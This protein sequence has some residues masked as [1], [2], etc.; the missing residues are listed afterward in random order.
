ME[1]RVTLQFSRFIFTGRIS[2]VA[3]LRIAAQ[4]SGGKIRE[5]R[6]DTFSFSA[7]TLSRRCVRNSSFIRLFFPC[8]THRYKLGPRDEIVARN[9]EN[10]S[11]FCLF[12]RKSAT[13]R[14]EFE[15]CH[16]AKLPT[17]N[18]HNNSHRRHSSSSKSSTV[19]RRSP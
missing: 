9:G 19:S 11:S 6:A 16:E 1:I 15:M 4:I 8:D 2:C 5:I 12:S 14:E 3:S 7:T 17:W 13:R 18:I 10:R